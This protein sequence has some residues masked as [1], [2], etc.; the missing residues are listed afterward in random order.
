M[1]IV[2]IFIS[3]EKT[4]NNTQMKNFLIILFASSIFLSC[5]KTLTPTQILV[6]DK[7]EVIGGTKTDLQF[8]PISEEFVGEVTGSDSLKLL[9]T[10]YEE[11]FNEKLKLEIDPYD[12]DSINTFFSKRKE[13]NDEIL[14][15]N[16][17]LKESIFNLIRVTGKTITTIKGMN[18]YGR[19]LKQYGAENDNIKNIK[20]AL[21]K[22]EDKYVKFETNKD[23]VYFRLLKSKYSIV[24]PLMNNAKQEIETVYILTPDTSAIVGKKDI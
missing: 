17:E 23:K 18:Q 3:F 13:T 10:A 4:I 12:F 7:V 11:F 24:N 21:K 20:I 22:F 1:C 9:K 8:K 6:K 14:R 15:K 16:E 2:K 5:E 19:V